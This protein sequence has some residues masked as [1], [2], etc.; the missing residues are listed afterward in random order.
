MPH[1]QRW[2][3]CFCL[4]GLQRLLHELDLLPVQHAVRQQQ[5][6]VQ[7]AS[8]FRVRDLLAGASP[9]GTSPSEGYWADSEVLAWQFAI[10]LVEN[11]AY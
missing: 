1:P 7:S 6:D 10:S 11:Q 8:G 2:L 4:Y 3:P 9:L 5:P